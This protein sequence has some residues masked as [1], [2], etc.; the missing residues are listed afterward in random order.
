MSRWASSVYPSLATL[1]DRRSR[2]SMRALGRRT[3]RKVSSASSLCR[4]AISLELRPHP[5]QRRN[6]SRAS[7]LKTI[8][9]IGILNFRFDSAAAES[10]LENDPFLF[11]PNLGRLKDLI[12]GLWFRFVNFPLDSLSSLRIGQWYCWL[13]SGTSRRLNGGDT[14]V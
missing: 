2:I 6:L 4:I 13:N 5:G 14:D 7:L 11:D 8:P 10:V 12:A 1:N 3:V 9:N